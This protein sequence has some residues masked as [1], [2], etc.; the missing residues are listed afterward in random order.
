MNIQIL[1]QSPSDA[2]TEVWFYS[3]PL[4]LNSRDLPEGIVLR[5]QAENEEERPSDQECTLGRKRILLRSLT[6]KLGG[7]ERMEF[8][9]I[10]GGSLNQALE[11]HR[12][13]EVFI[14]VLDDAEAIYPVWK[15]SYCLP[16]NTLH[17]SANQR[18]RRILLK[19]FYSLPK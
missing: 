7:N 1:S 10:R 5:A 3:N 15:D 11:S 16:I 9:R 18:K 8:F 19:Q 2:I 17:Y 12:E 13:P 6:T 4:S 14:Q